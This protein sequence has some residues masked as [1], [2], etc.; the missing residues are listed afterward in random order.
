MKY[1]VNRFQALKL[2]N[3]C[4]KIYCTSK[5][6]MAK[7]IKNPSVVG[8]DLEVWKIFYRPDR[9]SRF[10]FSP[11]RYFTY[12]KG[13][14]YSN[15]NKK[16]FSFV[17]PLEQLNII[18][19]HEGLHAFLE[20]KKA[21]LHSYLYVHKYNQEVIKCIIPRGSLYYKDDTQIVSNNLFIP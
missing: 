15:G 2:I 14:L 8:K 16:P 17:K 20:S 12:E 10:L 18:E 9:N 7:L 13:F 19:I 11:C 21:H 3:M 1:F 6:E 4:L 5:S